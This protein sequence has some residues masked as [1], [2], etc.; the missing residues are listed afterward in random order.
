[1]TPGSKDYEQ[2]PVTQQSVAGKAGVEDRPPGDPGQ[3]REEIKETREELG[4]TVE[5]LVQKTDVKGQLQE[6]VAAR[7]ERLRA[8][9]EQARQRMA[10]VGR[11]ARERRTPLTTAAA[12][13]VAGLVVVWL[14]RSD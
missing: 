11:Q 5:A 1:M 7:K 9:Q 2:Q 6:R 13:L 8:A 3:L 14:V 12:V 10:S 4:E